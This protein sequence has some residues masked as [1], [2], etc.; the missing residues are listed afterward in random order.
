M[1]ILL[2]VNLSVFM[3]FVNQECYSYN[4]KKQFCSSRIVIPINLFPNVRFVNKLNVSLYVAKYGHVIRQVS[5]QSVP[6]LKY[7]RLFAPI[8]CKFPKGQYI[9]FGIWNPVVDFGGLPN[10]KGG[11][12]NDCAS[13]HP[14]ENM[15]RKHLQFLLFDRNCD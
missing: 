6:D 1:N 7:N 9:L 10:E 4:I 11:M 12:I 3:F 5:E 2:C 13:L 14:I 15:F 8:D